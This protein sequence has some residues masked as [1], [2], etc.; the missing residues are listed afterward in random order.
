MEHFLRTVPELVIR[1]M[2]YAPCVMERT[3]DEGFMRRSVAGSLAKWHRA[4]P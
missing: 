2:P 1:L 4:Q 3:C